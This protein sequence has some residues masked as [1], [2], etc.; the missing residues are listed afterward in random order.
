MSG[1]VGGGGGGGVASRLIINAHANAAS[2]IV[3]TIIFAAFE[4]SVGRF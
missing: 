2:G 1:I 3:G 4:H